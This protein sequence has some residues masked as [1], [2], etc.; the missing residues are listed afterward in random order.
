MIGTSETLTPV[1]G[2]IR[3]AD[4]LK[5]FYDYLK[6]R[7]GSAINNTTAS[8]NAILGKLSNN[9]NRA[10]NLTDFVAKTTDNYIDVIVHYSSP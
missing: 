10:I 8:I 4:D 2:D 9:V 3:I 6:R 1:G 5:P 7:I